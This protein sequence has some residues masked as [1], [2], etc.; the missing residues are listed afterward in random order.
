G[1]DAASV[2]RRAMAQDVVLAPGNVFSVSQSA[3]GMMR[4][5]V[6]QCADPRVFSVLARAMEGAAAE[7]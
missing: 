2:A 5:N 7:G 1:I 3:G 6:A 4:F